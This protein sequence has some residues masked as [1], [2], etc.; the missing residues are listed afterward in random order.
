MMDHRAPIDRVPSWVR[1]YL[2]EWR[3][4]HNEE[5]LTRFD[6]R[7]LKELTIYEIDKLY[8]EATDADRAAVGFIMQEIETE[9]SRPA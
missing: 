5:Y 3:N 9:Q 4:A 7:G 6:R 8:R 2:L 1:S